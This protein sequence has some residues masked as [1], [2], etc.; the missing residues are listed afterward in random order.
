MSDKAEQKN[1]ADGKRIAEL[2]AVS[3]A[4]ID[5]VSELGNVM[6]TLKLISEEDF[7][8]PEFDV[9]EAA[10]RSLVDLK[11]EGVAQKAQATRA[12]NTVN[13][14][15]SR[16]EPRKLGELGKGK[17][18]LTAKELHELLG[19]AETVEIAFSD[20]KSELAGLPAVSVPGAAFEFKRGRVSLNVPDFQI[21]GP[22]D[23]RGAR[24]LK[25]YA[26]LIDGK[27][28]AWAPRLAGSTVLGAGVTY[29][30]KDDIALV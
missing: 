26:L 21:T 13:V 5:K 19:Q 29:Q 15:A 11:R 14:L 6:L 30:L 2:E 7:T 20:G 24:V 18:Q 22:A 10:A 3:A 8:D 9:L 27:Q 1:S 16:V 28:V 4:M 17:K 23:E 25:G 12:K